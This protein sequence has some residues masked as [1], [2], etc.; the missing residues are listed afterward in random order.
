MRAMFFGA[1]A[2][3]QPIGSWD[4]SNVTNMSRMFFEVHHHLI[5]Q[6]VIGIQVKLQIW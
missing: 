3:N 1:S 4:T 5:N 6:L 2:F